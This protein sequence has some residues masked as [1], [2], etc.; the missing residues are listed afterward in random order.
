MAVYACTFNEEGKHSHPQMTLLY[1][2]PSQDGINNWKKIKFLAAPP[3]T[4]SVVFGGD[5][6]KQCFLNKGFKEISIGTAP[7]HIKVVGKNIQG[8]QKQY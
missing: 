7:E 5:L 2:L 8:Q 1:D 3:R 6:P 4:R